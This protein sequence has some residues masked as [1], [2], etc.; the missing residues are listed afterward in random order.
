ME[1]CQRPCRSPSKHQF[2]FLCPLMQSLCYSRV[3]SRDQIFSKETYSSSYKYIFSN[4]QTNIFSWRGE[5]QN[6]PEIPFYAATIELQGTQ[7]TV[8]STQ[9]AN[10]SSSLFLLTNLPS[11]I[12]LHD[13]LILVKGRDQ[14]G[15]CPE[16]QYKCLINNTLSLSYICSGVCPTSA[17]NSC[18]PRSLPWVLL[19]TTA[20]PTNLR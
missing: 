18:L 13:V 6:D 4:L 3:V 12:I 10:Y 14:S 1:P 15:S 17:I 16:W 2:L 20:S 19:I 9:T 11:A 8:L 7:C 5:N